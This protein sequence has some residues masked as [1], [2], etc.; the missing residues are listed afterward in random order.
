[1]TYETYED[2]ASALESGDLHP[3]DAKSTLADYLDEL[4]DPGRQKLRE[5]RA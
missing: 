2:L 3:A 5:L 4:I 1:V